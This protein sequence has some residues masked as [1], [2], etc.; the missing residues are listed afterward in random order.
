M[1]RQTGIC[2]NL[3]QQF[4]RVQSQMA[5]DINEKEDFIDKLKAENTKLQVRPRIFWSLLLP[6]SGRHKKIRQRGKTL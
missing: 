6:R 2:G 3:E 1:K 4:A 5:S